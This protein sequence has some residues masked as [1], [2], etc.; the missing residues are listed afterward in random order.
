M[1]RSRK[2][3]QRGSNVEVLGVFLVDE[4]REDPNTTISGPS[5][6][7]QGNAISMAF[8]WRAD[9][10]PTLNAGLVAL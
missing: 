2:F 4:G 10:G 3:C 7:C 1:R 9:D 6:A 5:L 8:C